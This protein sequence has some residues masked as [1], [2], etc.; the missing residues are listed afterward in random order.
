MKCPLC[1]G[2]LSVDS[3]HKWILCNS[4]NHKYKLTDFDDDTRKTITLKMLSDSV[5]EVKGM[6]TNYDGELPELQKAHFAGQ[7]GA[8]RSMAD[9]LRDTDWRDYESLNPSKPDDNHGK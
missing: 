4:N 1:D 3:V 9:Y 7:M 6:I 2:D 8:W 5:M